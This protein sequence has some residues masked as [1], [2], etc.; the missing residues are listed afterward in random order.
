MG[1]IYYDLSEQFLS[2]GIKFKYYGIAR[3]VMEVGY[4]LS[5]SSAD[6]RFVVFSPAHD[7]FFEVKPRIG[8][9]SVTGVFDPNLPAEAKPLRLRYSFLNHTGCA[10]RFIQQ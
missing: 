9:A 6:V 4:E 10:M 3:T 5:L 8:A 7:R 2:S 1:P